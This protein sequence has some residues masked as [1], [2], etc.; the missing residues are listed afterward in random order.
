MGQYAED[1][2]RMVKSA[3]AGFTD[4]FNIPS[5]AVGFVAPEARTPGGRRPVTCR[6]WVQPAA[7]RRRVAF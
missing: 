4:P 3:V 5:A 7:W 6:A 2:G 1:V